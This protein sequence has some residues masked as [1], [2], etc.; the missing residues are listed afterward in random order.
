V[1]EVRGVSGLGIVDDTEEE[2]DTVDENRE[3]V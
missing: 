1:R 3:E 2:G